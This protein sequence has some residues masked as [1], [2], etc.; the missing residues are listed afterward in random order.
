MGNRRVKI[1]WGPWNDWRGWARDFVLA[2]VVGLFMAFIFGIVCGYR[3][4]G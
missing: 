4:R 2:V 1:G 3:T